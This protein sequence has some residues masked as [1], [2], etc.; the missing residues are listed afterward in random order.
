[1]KQRLTGAIAVLA[2]LAMSAPGLA[3]VTYTPIPEFGDGPTVGLID[4][5]SPG[6]LNDVYLSSGFGAAQSETFVFTFGLHLTQQMMSS[7][8]QFSFFYDNSSIE[9]LHADNVHPAHMVDAWASL[10]T[11]GTSGIWPNPSSGIQGLFMLTLGAAG[12]G[13]APF[14]NPASEIIPFLQVTLHV[15]SAVESQLNYFGVTFDGVHEP[16][17]QGFQLTSSGVV[18]VGPSEFSYGSGLIH[19][20]PEPSS[21]A[22]IAGGFALMGGV[23]A[24]RRRGA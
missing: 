8:Y 3:V 24:R 19:E 5:N 4:P 22:L 1:M 17:S 6:V 10:G 16:W 23:F 13:G 12:T 7:G 9:V 15:K 11:T 14:T 21:L 2:V 20:V 18:V